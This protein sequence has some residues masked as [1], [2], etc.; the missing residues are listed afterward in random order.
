MGQ[1]Q[2]GRVLTYDDPRTPEI[3]EVRRAWS[4]RSFDLEASVRRQFGSLDSWPIRRLW[5]AI[6][7]VGESLSH[8]NS[9]RRKVW[10][11]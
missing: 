4:Q 9:V 6:D 5:M 3:E 7:S 10:K 1:L 2:E 8:A 11:V